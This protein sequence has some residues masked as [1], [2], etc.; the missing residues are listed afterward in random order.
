MVWNALC[1]RIGLAFVLATQLEDL[2]CNEPHIESYF[3][4]VWDYDLEDIN[5]SQFKFFQ[6]QQH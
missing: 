3:F 5:V 1:N 4:L 6:M 2:A